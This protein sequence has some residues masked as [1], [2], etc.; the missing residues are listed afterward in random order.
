MDIVLPN[1]NYNLDRGDAKREVDKLLKDKK[2]VEKECQ[3]LIEFIESDRSL[4]KFHGQ[5]P[6][7]TWIR[8][9]IALWNQGDHEAM[10]MGY[11]IC[12]PVG[13]GKT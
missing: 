7:K 1:S 4:D 8:Q 2:L 6:V 13:T 12:G 11:L 9:D 5:D 10:P 3:G